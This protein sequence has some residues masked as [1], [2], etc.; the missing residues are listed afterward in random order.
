VPALLCPRLTTGRAGILHY[1]DKTALVFASS[2]LPCVFA[3]GLSLVLS[4]RRLKDNKKAG[5]SGQPSG[6]RHLLKTLIATNAVAVLIQLCGAMLFAGALLAG[7]STGSDLRGGVALVLLSRHLPSAAN[8]TQIYTVVQ[9]LCC[10]V[11]CL[12]RFRR[13]FWPKASQVSE[14]GPEDGEDG[15]DVGNRSL[16]SVVTTVGYGK[17]SSK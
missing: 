10:F 4:H 1:I 11:P 14:A 8:T 15:K 5:T 12:A 9:L 6:Y 3:S 2:L 17:L 16:E 13:W 7:G